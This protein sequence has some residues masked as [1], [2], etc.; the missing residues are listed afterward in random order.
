MPG[1]P[2]GAVDEQRRVPDSVRDI[3]GGAVHSVL[4]GR[5]AVDAI[6]ASAAPAAHPR[7]PDLTNRLPHHLHLR[8]HLLLLH[9][10]QGG[11]HR[12]CVHCPWSTRLLC[13]HTLAEQ[14]LISQKRL[15]LLQSSLLETVFMFA[16]KLQRY[17]IFLM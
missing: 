1:D 16:R 2:R 3:R 12:R 14:T 17:M 11:R 4:S 10:P 5:V 7:Q 6:Q 15:Q 9:T 8:R 13:L